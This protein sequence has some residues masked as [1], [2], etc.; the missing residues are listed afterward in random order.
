MV[1]RRAA[2]NVRAFMCFAYRPSIPPS[3]VASFL[4]TFVQLLEKEQVAEYQAARGRRPARARD[5]GHPAPADTQPRKKK[6][7]RSEKAAQGA[8]DD[9]ASPAPR[10][11]KRRR[12][13]EGEAVA[14]PIPPPAVLS[15]V[16]LGINHVTKRLE[17][18]L[19][20]LTSAKRAVIGNAPSAQSQPPALKYVL[21]CTGDIDPGA[22]VAHIPHLVAGCNSNAITDVVVL[23]PLPKGSEAQLARAF[24]L[25]R[26]SVV[27]IA[28]RRLSH[29]LLSLTT[30]AEFR[31]AQR[32]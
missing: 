19:E 15:H 7:K 12:V 13:Q 27:G 26:A 28:V 2:A 17:G 16:V 5:A 6:R 1:R 21:V 8:V 10:E 32:P 18:Q 20:A 22:L 24:G 25:P 4:N 31:P 29:Y 23:V 30:L 9:G 11:H 3:V 14:D